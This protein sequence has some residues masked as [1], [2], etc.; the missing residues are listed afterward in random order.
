MTGTKR[1][2]PP[3]GSSSRKGVLQQTVVLRRVR[4]T[5][6]SMLHWVELFVAARCKFRPRHQRTGRSPICI[7]RHWREMA[8]QPGRQIRLLPA[9]QN[10]IP[11]CNAISR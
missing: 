11:S 3:C 4:L 1:H 7:K 5:N 8:L 2:T 6:Q 10:G 9:H